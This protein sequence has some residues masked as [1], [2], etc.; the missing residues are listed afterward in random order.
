MARDQV[1]L[2]KTFYLQATPLLPRT[3]RYEIR[4]W[5]WDGNIISIVVRNEKSVG[6]LQL[7]H[8]KD[9][10][11][12]YSLSSFPYSGECCKFDNGNCEALTAQWLRPIDTLHHWPSQSAGH[13]TK[14]EKSQNAAVRGLGC[15]KSIDFMIKEGPSRFVDTKFGLYMNVSIVKAARSFHWVEMEFLFSNKR[16]EYAGYNQGWLRVSAI[17]YTR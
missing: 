9:T 6:S 7:Q 14:K 3:V 15:Q 16:F 5:V 2:V 4:F 10:P 12:I 8:T 17:P 13:L 11:M 1:N